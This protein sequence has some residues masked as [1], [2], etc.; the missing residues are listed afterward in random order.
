LL[1]VEWSAADSA[2]EVKLAPPP[3]LAAPIATVDGRTRRQRKGALRV[4]NA[5]AA[6]AL[7][8]RTGL[9]HAR[10]NA[11]LNHQ[12]GLRG[13]TEATVDQLEERVEQAD[14]WLSRA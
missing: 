10:A 12:V 13:I 4:A 3:V 6:R 11:E 7:A 2:I 8:H 1:P 9:S 14:R 5:A